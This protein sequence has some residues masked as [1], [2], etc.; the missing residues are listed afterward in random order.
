MRFSILK[1]DKDNTQH[2]TVKPAEWLME[3]IQTD[4]K[5]GIIGK[6]RFHI[7][8]NGDD[9]VFEQKT[10][11]A[12]IHP[13]VEMKKT[14]NGNLEIIA[15]NGLIT[16]HIPNLLSQKDIEAVKEASMQLPMTFAAF[17]GADGRSV[18]VLV[19]VARNGNVNA[20]LNFN[21]NGNKDQYEKT[22]KV[23]VNVMVNE[24]EIDAFCKTAY[25]QAI[26]VYSGILP[27]P[28][29]RQAVS[30]RS[31][32]RMTVDPSPYYHPEATPLLISTKTKTITGTGTLTGTSELGLG[33]ALTS[34]SESGLAL[35]LTSEITSP[36]IKLYAVYE[37]MYKQAAEKAK[38]ETADVIESQRYHA[39]ITELTRLLCE[40]GVP[41]EEAFLHLRDHHIY[42]DTYDEDTFRSIVAAVYA[43]NMPGNLEDTETVSQATR[44]LINHLNSR[45]VFRFNTVMGYTEYRPNNTGAYGWKPCDENAINGMT[46][47]ARL[48]NLDVR[49]KDVRR[50]V[51]SDM[52]RQSDPIFDYLENAS[53]AW[54]GKTDHIAMLARCVPCD[55][56]QW[57]LWFKK[58]FL[59]MVAQWVMPQ[60]E[61]GNAIVPL[62][63]S[64]QGDGKTSFCRMILPYELRWGFLEN[65]D[66]SEKRATLQA[67]HNFL[68]INLDEFNQ[69]SPKLQAGFLKNVIQLPNVKIKRPYGKHVEEFKRYASFIA[70]TNEVSVLSD[71]TGSRRFICVPL[72]APVD[73]SYKPN[74]EA[75]YGQ[76]YTMVMDRQMDWWFNAKETKEIM[77]H[78]RQFQII[79][80]AIQYFN[81][82]FEPAADED[83]GT[84]MSPTAIYE[85]LRSKA[86]SGLKANGVSSFGRYLRPTPGLKQK[87]TKNGVYYLVR[88]K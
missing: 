11:I 26:G 32:F 71:P 60:R 78:N 50:Y 65:L 27:Y 31:C 67:M 35:T 6:L 51:H 28:I 83:S 46:I 25:E 41:E 64:P 36:D 88:R 70:T 42:K 1:T 29:E 44:R 7:A 69:I 59:Y 2:L 55:I 81:E 15:F 53:K 77:E 9:G 43:E 52:I 61:Y 57:E 82:H 18:E 62:L 37:Q 72:T 10:P 20:N 33:L 17:M 74:Y 75:L 13:S 48:A 40:M 14:E 39:Y 38:A 34:T 4:T 80:P 85:E 76:A 73:T 47:K 49:D 21:G 12:M 8:Y 22:V 79:P 58:W 30:A 24:Q 5:A 84:W 23:N 68:L 54:D 86:G 16:L 87:R 63:I 19:A 45:Y 56:P 66:V 3:H